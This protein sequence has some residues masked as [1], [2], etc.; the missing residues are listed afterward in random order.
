[1][2]WKN[3]TYTRALGWA[4]AHRLSCNVAKRWAKADLTVHAL[5]MERNS[6]G[7]FQCQP[8]M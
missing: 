7:V 5:S 2:E 8:Q 3:E 1:M 6:S 4:L